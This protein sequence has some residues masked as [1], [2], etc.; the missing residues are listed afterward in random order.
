[1][2]VVRTKTY[3]KALKRLEKLGATAG[4]TA[5]MEQA[6]VADPSQG[7]VIPGTGGLR[8]IRF[9][10]GGTGKSGGG[11]TI[12]YVLEGDV[13]IL[14]TAYA[15]VDRS[16]VTAAEKRLF[17]TLIEELINGRKEN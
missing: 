11:R 8:K 14:I 5:R 1:V 15:K 13:L 2:E 9:A 6:I 3:G 17:R 16:D 4:D 7:D 10:Y 12:Y